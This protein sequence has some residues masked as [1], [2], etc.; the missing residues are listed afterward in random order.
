MLK[1]FRLKH[2]VALLLTIKWD[3]SEESFSEFMVWFP[4]PFELRHAVQKSSGRWPANPRH[5]RW[6][7]QPTFCLLRF[8][9]GHSR[10]DSG[11]SWLGLLGEVWASVGGPQFGLPFWWRPPPP[12]HMECQNQASLVQISKYFWTSWVSLA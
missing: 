3:Q 11:V 10:P 4:I 12:P 1:L 6:N 5:C 8:S 2:K 7:S 9:A